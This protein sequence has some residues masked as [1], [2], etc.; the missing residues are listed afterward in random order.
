MRGCGLVDV[1]QLLLARQG[2]EVNEAAADGATALHAASQKGH[3]EVVRLLLAR[4]R[5]STP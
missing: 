4:T 5:T 1:V 2:V 3:V